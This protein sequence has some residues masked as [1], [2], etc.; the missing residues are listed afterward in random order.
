MTVDE[1]VKQADLQVRAASDQLDA[2][3]TGGY[4]GDL[5]SA[6]MANARLGNIW[7]TWHVHPNIVAVAVMVK[8]AAIVL[9]SGRE[10][11]AET[12]R[13]AEQEGVPILITKLS[14]FELVGRLHGMGISG[15]Q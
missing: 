7:V 14:A 5:L 2:E 15:L 9:I 10:P 3:V 12:I 13:K 6:V 1:I 8:V 4:V 11:E